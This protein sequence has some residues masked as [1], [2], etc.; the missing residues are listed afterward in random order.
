MSRIPERFRHFSF[1]GYTNAFSFLP[2]ECTRLYPTETLFGDW[3][4]PVLLLVNDAGP[5]GN[6]RKL[7]EREGDLGWRHAQRARGDSS[8]WRTNEGLTELVRSFGLPTPLYG[9]ATAHM[10]CDAEGFSRSL[11]GFYKGPLH[12]FLCEVLRWT[13]AGMPNLRVI[14]CLGADAWFLTAAVLGHRDAD[15]RAAE[16]RDSEHALHGLSGGRQ[17]AA[18]SHFPPSRGDRAQR[19]LGWRLLARLARGEPERAAA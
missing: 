13:I 6:A 15:R 10:M 16:F 18:T 1:P 19:E 8:G 12:E 4:S 9:T 3:N 7:V 17:V 14:G 2:R 11:P 5:T